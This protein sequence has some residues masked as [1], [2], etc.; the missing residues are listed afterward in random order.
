MEA[1]SVDLDDDELRALNA[2]FPRSLASAMI[3][4][5]A[6]E[7][8]KIHFRRTDPKCRFSRPR[9]GADL[10]VHFSDGQNRLVLEIKGT[11]ASSISWQKLKVSSKHSWRYL[12]QERIPVY[13]VIN[14]FGKVPSIIELL[15]DRDFILEPEPRWSFK[16]KR[17][18]AAPNRHATRPG[19]SKSLLAAPGSRASKYAPLVA[20]LSR[21]KTKAVTLRFAEAKTVLGFQLPTS[22]TK[23][24]AFWANQT[25]TRLRPWARAWREAGYRVESFKLHPTRGWVRFTRVES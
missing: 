23:Y 4:K 25:D 14:V 21:Q 17:S 9:D 22:A 1:L 7:I 19:A 16:P 10:E 8:V 15:H 5:R 18:P 20:Y 13:R 12:V 2:K 11:E 24:Q 3:G 6:E